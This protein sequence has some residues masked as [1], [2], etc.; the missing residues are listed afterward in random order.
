V[1][2]WTKPKAKDPDDIPMLESTSQ[3]A[4]WVGEEAFVGVE[5][6]TKQGVGLGLGFQV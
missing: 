2:A 6:T 4:H 5:K 3:L 1:V